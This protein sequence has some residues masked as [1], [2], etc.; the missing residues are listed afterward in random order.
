MSKCNINSRYRSNNDAVISEIT[1]N[2]QLSL[3]KSANYFIV[4]SICWYSS[5][6][7]YHRLFILIA[8]LTYFVSNSQFM[9]IQYGIYLMFRNVLF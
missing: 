1:V 8:A 6:T 9:T 3:G 7:A 4:K 5:A 2:T